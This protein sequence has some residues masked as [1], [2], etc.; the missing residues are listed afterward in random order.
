MIKSVVWCRCGAGWIEDEVEKKLLDLH[1]FFLAAALHL[2]GVRRRAP[3][4]PGCRRSVNPLSLAGWFPP[5]PCLW[6]AL[7][8][9]V[10]TNSVG[11]K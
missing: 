10:F 4:F 6:E 1:G 8:S 7:G 3:A 5:P 11:G 2:F 9:A